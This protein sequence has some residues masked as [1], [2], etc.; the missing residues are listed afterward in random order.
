LSPKGFIAVPFGRLQPYAQ[1]I[2]VLADAVNGFKRNVIN[3]TQYDRLVTEIV[4]SMGMNTLDSSFQQGWQKMARFLDMS[5]IQNTAGSLGSELAGSAFSGL[6]LPLGA[7]QPYETMQ[8]DKVDGFSNFISRAT[9]RATGGIGNPIQ[10]NRYTGEPILKAGRQGAGY[11]EGV[12]N[13]LINILGY[14][15]LI[16][17]AGAETPVFKEMQKTAYDTNKWNNNNRVKTLGSSTKL[18]LSELST[19]DQLTGDPKVG[20]LQRKLVELFESGLYK[21]AMKE[22]RSFRKGVNPAKNLLGAEDSSRNLLGKIHGMI[23]A[24]HNEA[25][26]QALE[27]MIR[28]GDY[29]KLIERREATNVNSLINF[30][31]R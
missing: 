31:Q 10:Y 20:A 24:V 18:T 11:W 16:K 2:S 25:R 4:I 13:N 28:S 3:T 1:Y 8:G 21:N 6:R 12:G 29:P 19:L 27:A 23:D 17:D 5:N 22:Y 15:G 26:S 14:P 30:S 9:Q 7:L